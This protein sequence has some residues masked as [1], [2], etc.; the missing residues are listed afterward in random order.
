MICL[1]VVFLWC[2]W[3]E[4]MELV[5]IGLVIF[6][7]D[8]LN[9]SVRCIGLLLVVMLVEK[10]MWYFMLLVEVCLLCLNLFLN[11][12][13]SLWGFLFRVLISMFR[14]SWWVM[15]IIM[16]LMLFLLVLWMMVFIIGISELLFFSEKCFWLMYLV[17]RQCFRFLVV[18][19]CFRV[20]CWVLVF[21][22]QLLLVVFSFL[23]IYWCCLILE[24][25]MNFVLIELVQVVFRCVSRLC[26]FMCGWLLMLLV[27]NLLLRLVLD[28]LWNGRFRLG[29]LIGVV[30]FSGLRWVFRW[31][32]EWQVVIR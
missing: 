28:R 22:W 26:S 24:M 17:C 29:V 31:L 15:L 25:C 16:F 20:W 8:G 32:C 7:C 14:W 19:R 13:N 30:R 10:F 3:C 11:L 23:Q 18:V 9:V 6:R 27:L 2:F 5:M 1:C 12:L 21:S 4:C